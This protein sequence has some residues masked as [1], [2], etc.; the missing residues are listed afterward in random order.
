MK[1]SKMPWAGFEPQNH[2]KQQLHHATPPVATYLLSGLKSVEK[3]DRA[4]PGETK[5][6]PTTN[7]PVKP[8]LYKPEMVFFMMKCE[9]QK[10]WHT[11]TSD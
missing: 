5:A 3:L 6:M 7:S 11:F 9:L 1:P 4:N 10:S 8:Y 2:S